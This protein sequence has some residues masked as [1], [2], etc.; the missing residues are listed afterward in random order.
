MPRHRAAAAPCPATLQEDICEEP[1]PRMWWPREIWGRYADSLEDFK[2]PEHAGAAVQCLNHMVGGGGWC[3]VP[4]RAALRRAA[5][6]TAAAMPRSCRPLP[7]PA[8]HLPASPSPSALPNPPLLSCLRRSQTRWATWTPASPTWLYCSSPTCL[9]SAP[10]P[11]HGGGGV[12]G[13][14]GP[15]GLQGSVPAA[16]AP[17]RGP[18]PAPLRAPLR[19]DLPRHT[20]PSPHHL[21][22][23][24]G[25]CHA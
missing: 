4:R 19:P 2:Q 14:A 23:D 9:P 22:S 15:A 20:R 8:A 5:W 10:S 12:V 18:L 17:H 1:R 25:H 3:G 6:R 11:R 13:G 16:H 21:S 24:H 7:T